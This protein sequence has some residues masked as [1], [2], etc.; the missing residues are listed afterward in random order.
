MEVRILTR[1]R[2]LLQAVR[3]DL[4]P[5]IPSV[6]CDAEGNPRVTSF[7]VSLYK[8][9]GD[10]VPLLHRTKLRYRRKDSSG[11]WTAWVDKQDSD[12]ITVPTGLYVQY[13]IEAYYGGALLT[14]LGVST[15][16]DGGMGSKGAQP[17]TRVWSPDASY[18]QGQGTEEW[19]DISLYRE[20]NSKPYERYLCLIS[21]GPRNITPKEDV[22]QKL[23]YWALATDFEFIATRLVLAEKITVDQID[24]DSIFAGTIQANDATINNFNATNVRIQSGEIG[25]FE[26]ANGRIGQVDANRGYGPS[27]TNTHIGIG[28]QRYGNAEEII[29]AGFGSYQSALTEHQGEALSVYQKMSSRANHGTLN[30]A[31]VIETHG[32]SEPSYNGR[33]AAGN[34]QTALRIIT[35]ESKKD[36]ALALVGK[37][38]VHDKNNPFREVYGQTVTI[39]FRDVWDPSSNKFRFADI[40]FINGLLTNISYH[41]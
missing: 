40:E 6:P 20:D 10:N 33:P 12:T 35:D 37:I 22:A 28:V 3:Y 26:I 18:M 8:T 32:G 23:G 21:H 39:G 41:D 14:S 31:V 24:V 27:I 9:V 25:G 19:Y 15:T 13:E 36:V 11:R 29:R 17:R 1:V 16:L 30:G 2:R 4:R 7:V 38:Q 34:R 5:D